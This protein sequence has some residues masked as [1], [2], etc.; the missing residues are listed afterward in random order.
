MIIITITTITII[1]T[2]ILFLNAQASSKG[3]GEFA[4]VDVQQLNWVE[5]NRKVIII[6]VI[7]LL[8]GIIIIV[9]VIMVFCQYLNSGEGILYLWVFVVINGKRQI[10]ACIMYQAC[11]NQDQNHQILIKQM[12]K[13]NLKRTEGSEGRTQETLDEV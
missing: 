7:I 4:D 9:I 12:A 10:K 13:I 11:I 2:T 6:I 5:D 1:V 3:G 8:F